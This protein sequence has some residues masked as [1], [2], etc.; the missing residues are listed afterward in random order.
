MGSATADLGCRC[1]WTYV[2]VFPLKFHP[3]NVNALNKSI[4]LSEYKGN[5]PSTLIDITHMTHSLSLC[6]FGHIPAVVKGKPL[7]ASFGWPAQSSSPS[8]VVRASFLPLC[9]AGERGGETLEG[10]WPNDY[11]KEA[12]TKEQDGTRH[13]WGSFSLVPVTQSVHLCSPCIKFLHHGTPWDHCYTHL[14]LSKL[15]GKTALS[16]PRCQ[17]DFI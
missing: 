5:P 17:T 13:G 1:N 9:P 6:S 4:F 16:R 10:P 8:L 7:T 15:V 12:R 14:K 2:S 3:K 11:S